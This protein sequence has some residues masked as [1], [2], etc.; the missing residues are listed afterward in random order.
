[1]HVSWSAVLVYLPCLTVAFFSESPGSTEDLLAH[2]GVDSG[3]ASKFRPRYYPDAGDAFF[4]RDLNDRLHVRDAT[5]YNL[6][7]SRHENQHEQQTLSR[8][9]LPKGYEEDVRL[10]ELSTQSMKKMNQ[11]AAK[12]KGGEIRTK[13]QENRMFQNRL[14]MEHAENQDGMVKLLA[15]VKEGKVGDAKDLE[16]IKR[17]IDEY[18]ESYSQYVGRIFGWGKSKG[19]GG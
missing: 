17:V 7:R 6:F 9:V 8:R 11:K 2:D 14:K 15:E 12:G 18:N 13:Y 1:M 19:A 16:R 10:L 3:E 4:T 5:L